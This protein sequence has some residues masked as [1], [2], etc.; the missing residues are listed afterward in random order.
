MKYQVDQDAVLGKVQG[1]VDTRYTYTG[2]LGEENLTLSRT[3][4][5]SL[6]EGVKFELCGE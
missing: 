5:R 4:Q 2:S 1:V 6:K 3:T